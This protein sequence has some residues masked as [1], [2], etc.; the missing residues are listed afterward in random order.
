MLIIKEETKFVSTK[1]DWY[2]NYPNNK[3]KVHIGLYNFN[4]L[5]TKITI[6]GADDYGLEI[7]LKGDNYNKLLELYNQISDFITKDEL[8]RMGFTRF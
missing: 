6:F 4:Y 5:Y 3:I 7:E 2:P 1:E 8:E